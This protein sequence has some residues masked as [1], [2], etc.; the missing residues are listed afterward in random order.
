MAT[1]L[2][3]LNSTS[4]PADERLEA[5]IAMILNLLSKM[6]SL[7]APNNIIVGTRIL[8][9]KETA[10]QKIKRI[11]K[12]LDPNL[13][14]PIES[15]IVKRY[16]CLRL[17]LKAEISKMR[18]YPIPEPWSS[19]IMK[20]AVTHLIEGEFIFYVDPEIEEDM[21]PVNPSKRDLLPRGY[22]TSRV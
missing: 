19:D 6:E 5:D 16:E 10:E 3:P 14:T 1:N 7:I 17:K 15:V 21:K 9:M 4:L 8:A 2:S 12:R 13:P 11:Q 20:K 22:Y 18:T